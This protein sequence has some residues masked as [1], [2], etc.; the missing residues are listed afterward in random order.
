MAFLQ[1]VNYYDGL[2]QR[3][4]K[5]V[6]T[7]RSFEFGIYRSSFHFTELVR[8]VNHPFHSFCAVP[9]YLLMVVCN[10]LSRSFLAD[11]LADKNQAILNNMNTR[12]ASVLK[13]KHLTLVE[14][15][16]SKLMGL[17][18]LSGTL[19]KRDHLQKKIW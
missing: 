18:H 8:F 15:D 4:D 13:G 16:G 3:G 11:E 19:L 7:M 6:K 5:L 14:K 2:K 9:D 10:V 12:C 1:E 17:Q